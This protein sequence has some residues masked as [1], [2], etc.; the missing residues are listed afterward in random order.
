MELTVS[1]VVF[2]SS[3]VC[4]LF[5]GGSSS[6]AGRERRFL[7]RASAVPAADA[8]GPAAAAKPPLVTQLKQVTDEGCESEPPASRR[9][10]ESHLVTHCNVSLRSCID[11]GFGLIVASLFVAS[12]RAN[13]M[14]IDQPARTSAAVLAVDEH[15]SQ[16]EEHGDTAWLDSML[17]PEYRSISADGMILDKKTLLTHAAT[18]RG[19]DKMIK[20]VAEWRKTHPT[21]RSV[22]IHGDVAIV[23]FSNPRTGQ[24]RS[25]DIFVY[26]RGG[27]HALYS[28][29]SKAD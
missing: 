21:S 4:S 23:S 16:A 26:Q 8:N 14:K 2:A 13:D 6:Q 15:W 25:S 24:V 22:V 29:H 27:W 19:S 18:N 17:L 11:L 28:Q 3:G 7:L 20:L 9:K 5:P 10:N 12:A 1:R